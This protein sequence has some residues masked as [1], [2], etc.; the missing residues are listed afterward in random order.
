MSSCG[1]TES[2]TDHPPAD[3]CTGQSVAE[4]VRPVGLTSDDGR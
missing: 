2:S 1:D 3:P 4:W